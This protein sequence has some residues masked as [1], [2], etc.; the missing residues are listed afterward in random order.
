M[1]KICLIVNVACCIL[2]YLDFVRGAVLSQSQQDADAGLQVLPRAD[3]THIPVQAAQSQRVAR[4]RHHVTSRL[5][6]ATTPT[7]TH[8]HTRRNSEASRGMGTLHVN[9]CYT[10]RQQ[11]SYIHSHPHYIQYIKYC[12]CVK[13]WLYERH[14]V[15]IEAVLCHPGDEGGLTH[16]LCHPPQSLPGSAA[17]D[18]VRVVQRPHHQ[19]QGWLPHLLWAQGAL[20]LCQAL[21]TPRGREENSLSTVPKDTQYNTEV[22]EFRN[23]GERLLIC[24]FNIFID[25]NSA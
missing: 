11:S 14:L 6:P 19:R 21:Q 2:K 1:G 4:P 18:G 13:V 5:Q 9:L 7:H 12:M 16:H 15:L 20:V 24:V 3:A 23:S 17:K 8:T 22:C 10:D 25:W